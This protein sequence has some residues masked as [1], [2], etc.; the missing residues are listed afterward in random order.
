MDKNH[1]NLAMSA[2]IGA[3]GILNNQK[4]CLICVFTFNIIINESHLKCVLGLEILLNDSSVDL[5]FINT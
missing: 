5:Q 2:R 1:D 3:K 4:D